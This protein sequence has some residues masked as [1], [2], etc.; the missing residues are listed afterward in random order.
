ML[1]FVNSIDNL[2]VYGGHFLEDNF[3]IQLWK[4]TIAYWTEIETAIGYKA[5]SF[6]ELRLEEAKMNSEELAKLIALKNFHRVY[7]SVDEYF[8][9]NCSK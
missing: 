5:I 7:K 9:L 2:I 6:T 1:G 3:G 4:V 8:S